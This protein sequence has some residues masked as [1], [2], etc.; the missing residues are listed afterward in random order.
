MDAIQLLFGVL[1][2]L[3]ILVL[4][5]MNS[6]LIPLTLTQRKQEGFENAPQQNSPSQLESKIKDVL[7]FITVPELCPLF[8]TILDTMKKN[9]KAGQ[10]ISDEEVNRRVEKNL[11]LKIP[12]GALPCPLLTYPRPGS[13]DLEWL[14]FVNSIPDDYGARIVFMAIYAKEFLGKTE[15]DLKSALSGQRPA[16]AGAT[17]NFST[18]CPPDIAAS[19][20][21]DA[22][23]KQ[24]ESCV[25]PESLTSEQI[26]EAVTDK[27]KRIVGTKNRL[28][29]AKGIP[30]EI[31]IRPI[32]AEAKKSAAYLK[33][34]K[35]E[36]EQG[37]LAPTSSAPGL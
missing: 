32:I 36:T 12:G 35:T 15:M 33:Q 14:D 28:L 6:T 3:A 18:I 1:F 11:A 10:Q 27:L 31:D 19:R 20:R 23:R 9:E 5:G 29:Q 22:L 2:G 21:E 17:E 25:L 30:V 24:K 34:K 26:D 4:F 7:D 13:K 8:E 37:T 16:D